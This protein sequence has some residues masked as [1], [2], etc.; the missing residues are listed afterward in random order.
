MPCFQMQFETEHPVLFLSDSDSTS[1]PEDTSRAFVTS[2]DDCLSFF[3]LSSVDGA[4][5]V[6]VTDKACEANVPKLFTG[7]I[8]AAS[9]TLSVT[10]SQGFRYLNVP[11]PAGQVSVEIW[12]DDERNTD[13]VWVKLGAIQSY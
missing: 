2:T 3:V 13:W 4:S 7:G 6:T 12:A 1:T 8:A 10:D 11:V 9:G 5:L